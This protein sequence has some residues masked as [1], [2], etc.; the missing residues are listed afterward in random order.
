MPEVHWQRKP[1]GLQHQRSSSLQYSRQSDH[2]RVFGALL[3][4][5]AIAGLETVRPWMNPSFGGDVGIGGFGAA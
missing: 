1:N 5:L 3:I 2:A 4:D